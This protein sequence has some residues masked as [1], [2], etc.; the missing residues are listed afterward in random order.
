[1]KQDFNLSVEISPLRAKES[2]IKVQTVHNLVLSD[3]IQV[4][5][6]SDLLS[7]PCKEDKGIA[8]VDKLSTHFLNLRRK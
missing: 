6:C 4:E 3:R 7:F 1:M 2:R 5:K 8:L